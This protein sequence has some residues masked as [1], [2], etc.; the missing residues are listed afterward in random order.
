[1]IVY[2]DDVSAYFQVRQSQE[3][4]SDLEGSPVHVHT[5]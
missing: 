2:A 5:M 4:D 3:S 1:M